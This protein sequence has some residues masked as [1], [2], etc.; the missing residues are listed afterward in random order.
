MENNKYNLITFQNKEYEKIAK[1]NVS[2]KPDSMLRI[3]MVFKAIKS[4]IHI[5]QPN[6]KPFVRRGFTV[7]EWGGSEI[8]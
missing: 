2:P 5:E 4:P 3:F 6:I 1:L 7:V 8:K